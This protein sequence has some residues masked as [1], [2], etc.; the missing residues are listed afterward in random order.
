MPALT[1]DLSLVVDQSVTAAELLRTIADA[2]SE[3]LESI[4]LVDQYQGEGIGATKKSLTFT[5]L[6]R[7]GEKTLTQ[8]EANQVKLQAVEKCKAKFGAELRA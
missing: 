7:S 5:L 8:A 1:Q 4:R 6:F 2:C 3:L